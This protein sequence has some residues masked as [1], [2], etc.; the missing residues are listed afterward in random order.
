MVDPVDP[1]DPNDSRAS[2][3]LEAIEELKLP[4]WGAGP[5]VG[6]SSG[7]EDFEVV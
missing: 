6:D 2:R 1:V 3:G 7:A 4:F 5:R